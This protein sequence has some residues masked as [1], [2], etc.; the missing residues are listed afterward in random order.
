MLAGPNVVLPILQGVQLLSAVRANVPVGHGLH[1]LLGSSSCPE[2]QHL[3]SASPLAEVQL[4]KQLG[5]ALF[6]VLLQVAVEPAG[7][8]HLFA[9]GA[10]P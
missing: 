9:A 2:V 6:G 5:V 10:C 8:R 4:I 7:P 3:H 1:C